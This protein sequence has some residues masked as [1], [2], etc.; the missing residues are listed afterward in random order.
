MTII[1]WRSVGFRPICLDK[2]GIAFVKSVEVIEVRQFY[3]N[4]AYHAGYREPMK[5]CYR[6][7][8]LLVQRDDTWLA[9]RKSGFDSPAVQSRP[10]RDRA[11]VG[12]K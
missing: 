3:E 9:T 8:G 10:R 2:A 1:I 6:P 11:G 12:R 7:K 4:Q 5:S